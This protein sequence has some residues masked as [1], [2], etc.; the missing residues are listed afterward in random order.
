MM[1][2]NFS[3]APQSTGQPGSSSTSAEPSRDDTLRIDCP[4]QS[5]T[6]YS[7]ASGLLEQAPIAP[8]QPSMAPVQPC[9]AT[10][11]P[12]MATSGQEPGFQLP[13]TSAD[14]GDHISQRPSSGRS[15]NS[16]PVVPPIGESSGLKND[17]KEDDEEA[18]KV[19]TNAQ[20]DKKEQKAGLKTT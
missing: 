10:L 5:A 8:L 20:Q 3:M 17:P 4:F 16:N 9:M 1:N 11:P 12:Y 15:L 19:N 18:K 13:A 7:E 6:P 2:S 14:D